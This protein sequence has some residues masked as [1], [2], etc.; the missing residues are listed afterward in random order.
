MASELM[1]SP[2]CNS[3]ELSPVGVPKQMSLPAALEIEMEEEQSPVAL[4]QMQL[5]VTP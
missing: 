5:P 1:P 3:F 4:E 2:L